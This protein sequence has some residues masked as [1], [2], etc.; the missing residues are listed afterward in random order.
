MN[1]NVSW[2]VKVAMLSALSFVL[3]MFE[4]PLPVFPAWLKLD[5]ADLPALLGSFSLGP[6]AGI[7]IELVKIILHF[8]LKND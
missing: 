2:L 4:V 5:F 1:K 7:V 8:F 6:V 3:M